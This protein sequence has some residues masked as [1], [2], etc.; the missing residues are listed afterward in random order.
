MRVGRRCRRRPTRCAAVS[1]RCRPSRSV[2]SVARR[3]RC[4]SPRT[5]R[6]GRPEGAGDRN[7]LGA[8][9]RRAGA[10]AVGQVGLDAP[11]L[12]RVADAQLIAQDI[13]PGVNVGIVAHAARGAP[14]RTAATSPSS[15]CS[16]ATRSSS[17]ASPRAQAA[18][19]SR[20]STLG[21]RPSS[22]SEPAT[23]ETISVRSIEAILRAAT[24]P[25]AAANGAFR[26][27]GR[28]RRRVGA[29]GLRGF[30]AFRNY[31]RV[32]IQNHVGRA[33]QT[34]MACTP[35]A[36]R[37]A[38][39]DL[40][41]FSFAGDRAGCVSWTSRRVRLDCHALRRPP[42][43]RVERSVAGGTAGCSVQGLVLANMT[44]TGPLLVTRFQDMFA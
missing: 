38:G 44:R 26:R 20:A 4:K 29:G 19:S 37:S 3:P 6:G 25:S 7:H 12:L 35:L 16:A 9:G 43:G 8:A 2:R 21:S 33:P 34:A 28:G 5:G 24:I 17:L 18:A 36:D 40:G 23:V 32:S 1:R 27:Q 14:L 30:A 39:C 22:R 41:Y 10:L 42:T 11:Q 31:W 13:G 15:R